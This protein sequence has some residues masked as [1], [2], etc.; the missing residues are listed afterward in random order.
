MA[1]FGEAHAALR[2]A[3]KSAKGISLYSRWINRP[4]GRVLA[5]GAYVIGL[6]PNGVT[7]LS[8][9]ATA[10]GI[11][12]LIALP[13][14]VLTGLVVAVLLMLGFALDSS[15][16][17]LARLTGRSSAAGEWLDHV[18]DAGK[19]AAVHGGV[20]LALLFQLGQN[21]GLLLLPFAFQ[22][23]ACV[24]FA[25]LTV[26]DLLLRALPKDEDAPKAASMVRAVGM[27]PADYGILCVSFI[28]WGW[29][30]LF[31]VAYAAIF[32]LT[33]A[34]TVLLLIKWFRLLN[35]HSTRRTSLL[36][37]YLSEKT[38]PSSEG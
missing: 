22:I 12:A 34:I 36:E 15:D 11:V 20:L 19:Q 32:A 4:L 24:L 8:A 35:A 33:T 21:N 31:F 14:T 5:A 38:D 16:G 30:T 7:V 23:V 26:V 9:L 28:L 27:L 29:S 3:Q 25:G 17:Q 13:P 10:A 6:T 2:R 18:V 37:S 1:S